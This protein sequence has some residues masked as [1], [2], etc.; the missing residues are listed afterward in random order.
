M[1]WAVFFSIKGS[2]K[3]GGEEQATYQPCRHIYCAHRLNVKKFFSFVGKIAKTSLHK[4][5]PPAF[6]Y[7][8][9]DTQL[10]ESSD[11]NK[12]IFKCSARHK[13]RELTEK[14]R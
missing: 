9:K 3:A 12:H 1:V 11:E 5:Q 4:Q 14:V 8:S 10:K 7:V 6:I 13:Q 2:K